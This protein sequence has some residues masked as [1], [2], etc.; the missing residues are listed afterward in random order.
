MKETFSGKSRFFR[1]LHGRGVYVALAASILTF[2]GVAVAMLGQGLF[3]G[4][5]IPESSLPPEEMVEQLVTNQPDDRTT[6]VTTTTTVRTTT[7]TTAKAPELYILPLS[8]TVQKPYSIDNPL[9]CETMRDWRIHTG[10]DFAGE[11]NQPVKALAGGTVLAVEQDL[12]WGTCIILD[13]GVGVVSRYCGVKASVKKG[14]TV[15]VGQV[16]GTLD[17]I[18]CESLQSP[19]LH[20]EMFV[21][22]QPVDPV[23]A[24]AKEVRYADSTTQPER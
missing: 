2:G 18:P 6:T 1:F 24:L 7:T 8:N 21:D 19:H 4:E 20:L 11:A 15:E 23:T 16:V 12:M 3:H 13:H 9:Y 22:E 17:T 10:V 14:E 5:E